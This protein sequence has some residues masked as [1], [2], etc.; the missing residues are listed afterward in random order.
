MYLFM[1]VHMYIHMYIYIFILCVWLSR[2][3]Q[4]SLCECA[5][6]FYDI[7]THAPGRESRCAAHF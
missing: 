2:F 4:G 5:A 6:S 7:D 1:Y 3:Y